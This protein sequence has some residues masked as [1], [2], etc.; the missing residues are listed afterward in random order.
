MSLPPNAHMKTNYRQC[1][2]LYFYHSLRHHENYFKVFEE[3]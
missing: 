3:K 2:T 1:N